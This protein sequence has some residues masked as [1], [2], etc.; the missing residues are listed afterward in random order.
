M[1]KGRK[2][3]EIIILCSKVYSTCWENFA[4]FYF[5]SNSSAAKL[6]PTKYHD[7]NYFGAIVFFPFSFQLE[8]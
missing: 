2:R 8:T 4:H 6:F 3:C 7:T 5:A 1:T